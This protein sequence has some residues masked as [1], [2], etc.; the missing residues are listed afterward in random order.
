MT[1]PLPGIPLIESPL[2]PSL[3]A[4][5][6][7]TAGEARIA[8]SLATN[9]FAVI[10]FPDAELDSRIARIKANLA[11]RFVGVDLNDPASVKAGGDR[12]IQDAWTF[13]EDVKAIAC[14]QVVLDLLG[15][16]YGR[17]AFPFQTLNFPVGTQQ[18][19]HTDLVHFSSLPERFM[20][21]VW[22]AME[23]IDADAGPLHYW[24]GSH[25]WPALNNLLIGRQGYGSK[26]DSAQDPF[27]VAWRALVAAHQVEPQT[28]LAR[29][30]Q[31]LIWTANLLHGG[32]WQSDPHRTRWSQVTHY[33]FTDCIYYTPAFSDEA[34]GRLD[35]RNPV[36]I[37]DG[38]VH[39]G[40]H[41]GQDL[42]RR[43][44]GGGLGPRRALA[45]LLGR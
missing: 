35:V 31:A 23:D 40:R 16:L 36:S 28:F 41:L 3:Q 45:R 39:A 21:G 18:E 26:L 10:D 4:S 1:N 22:L 27:A 43:K 37:V 25:R 20:C 44:K 30:G 2:F 5:L 19:A 34:F 38:T 11:P 8:Q 9:G 32:G 12:R 42:P 6:N 13:D 7:L 14:N 33:Y 15:K 29:K 17:D 24:P